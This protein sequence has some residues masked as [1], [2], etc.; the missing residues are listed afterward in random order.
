MIERYDIMENINKGEDFF[1]GL[2]GTTINHVWDNL[3]NI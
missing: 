1:F 3:S 2:E